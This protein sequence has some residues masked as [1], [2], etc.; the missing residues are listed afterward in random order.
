[1]SITVTGTTASFQHN[2][3]KTVSECQYWNHPALCYSTR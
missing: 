2:L 1:M 3:D